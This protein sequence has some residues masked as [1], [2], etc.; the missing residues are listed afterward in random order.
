MWF[1]LVQLAVYIVMLLGRDA[2]GPHRRVRR[3]RDLPLGRRRDLLPACCSATSACRRRQLVVD[4][5]PA[6]SRPRGAA[7]RRLRRA[8]GGGRD[9]RRRRR[10]RPR[11]PGPRASS[12]TPLVAAPAVP[13]AVERP[14]PDRRPRSRSRRAR[15]RVRLLAPPAEARAGAG[16]SLS[17]WPSR[18]LSRR[19][20]RPSRDRGRRA[21]AQRPRRAAAP[22]ARL[23]RARRPQL[24]PDRHAGRLAARPRRCGTRRVEDFDAQV[25]FLARN[26]DVVG[27]ADTGT[28]RRRGRQVLITFDDGYRDNHAAALPILRAHGATATFFLATGFLDRSRLAWWDEVAWMVRTSARERDLRRRRGRRARRPGPRRRRSPTL[29]DRAKALPG[30]DLDGFLDRVALGDR[31]GPR[32]R[33]LGRTASG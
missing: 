8:R 25:G 1:T 10:P 7:R 14:R 28:A 3:G 23:A 12:P 26:F 29:L 27:P 2:M 18:P 17:G 19:H 22:R 16:R 20:A 32:A 4:A 24:P 33:P 30:A 5:G 21:R 31:H 6:A 11:S 9:R 13:E 15:S